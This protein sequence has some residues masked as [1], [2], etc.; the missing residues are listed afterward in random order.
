MIFS[1][2]AL[3]AGQGDCLLLHYGDSKTRKL[4]LIDGGPTGVYK[5]SLRPRLE[6][7]LSELAA[8]GRLELD[9]IMISHLDGDHIR[10]VLDLTDELI[11]KRQTGAI[12]VDATSIWLNT[13]KDVGAGARASSVNGEVQAAIASLSGESG[14]WRGDAEAVVASVP[15]GQRLRDNV[16]V[17]SWTQNP[18][19]DGPVMAPAKGGRKVNLGPL[20]LHVVAPLQSQITQLEKRWE[21]ETAKLAS[22][23][24]KVV[25]KAA[26]YLDQS[27]FNLSSI[28]CLAELGGKRILLT[29]DARGDQ[30]LDGLRAA[31]LLKEGGT[32][33]LD[34]LKLPHHGSD[35]NVA[36]DF[37]EALP[38]RHYVVSGD[39]TDDNPEV[40][41]LEMISAARA[42]DD[43]TIH[44]TYEDCKGGVGKKLAKHFAAERKRKRKYGVEFRPAAALSLQ[45]DLFEET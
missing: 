36:P 16:K 31:D 9:L 41:T 4:A 32:L 42:S 6:Q 45:V 15:Q 17:L 10:G 14:K 5:K 18:G 40:E 25:A 23:D 8:A 20:A 7:L 28:V 19:F 35:R 34:I 33:E 11:E 1:L 38:A 21:K 37:F 13:F 3:A 29:G 2:E 26:E 39:G 22:A 12:A 24:K 30:I 27:V 44:L 43:F